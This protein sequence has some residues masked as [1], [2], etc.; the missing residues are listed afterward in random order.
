MP[1]DLDIAV[2]SAAEARAFSLARDLADEFESAGCRSSLVIDR[3]PPVAAGHTSCLV[4]PHVEFDRWASAHVELVS[5]RLRHTVAICPGALGLDAALALRPARGV[6][7]PLP[8]TR[9]MLR[10]AGIDAL[11]LPVGWRGDVCDAGE[12][13]L[14]VVV[15]DNWTAARWRVLAGCARVLDG[16][17]CDL[18]ASYV[19]ASRAGVQHLP[20][21]EGRRAL[22]RRAR[23][24]M[25]VG[26]GPSLDL[27]AAIEA[28]A[29]GA[30][31][32]TDARLDMAPFSS[33]LNVVRADERA[34]PTVLDALLRDAPRLERIRGDAAEL[35][36]RLS[37]SHAVDAIVSMADSGSTSPR[38]R[39]P[40][41]PAAA[42]SASAEASPEIPAVATILTELR[43]LGRRVEGLEHRAAAGGALAPAFTT[44]PAWESVA[45][46]LSVVVPLHDYEDFVDTACASVAA[47]VGVQLELI[48]VDDAS[49]DHGAERVEAF[50]ADHPSLPAALARLPANVGIA[51]A[52][53]HG[54]GLARA[55]LVLFLDAD[56]VLLPHGSRLLLD[57]LELD[58]G[59]AFAYG[60][61]AIEG[62]EGPRGLLNAEPWN[63]DLLREGNYI[64]ALALVR[65]AAFDQIGGFRADGLLEL[66]WEDYDFWLRMAGAGLR[67]T[68]V[69]Q[70][71]ARY[72]AHEGSRTVT[73]DTV[74]AELMSYL[75][76]QHPEILGPAS[77]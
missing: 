46:E 27:L 60:L 25:V 15:C 20:D 12:R 51:G 8:A 42:A 71:V 58:P 13:D 54:R 18:R 44:T 19:G 70:L 47:A 59:A 48:V 40:R 26:N 57:A 34:L 4:V 36:R 50:L 63:P 11:P 72:R 39:L 62:P 14:D 41:A 24:A 43:R 28:A 67:G 68:Q 22:L 56:D 23:V 33:G 75:R 17:A 5:G 9:H 10:I 45:P 65:T 1:A 3:L 73:A 61:L 31:I 49:N 32:V 37:L 74:A 53:N 7:A 77:V 30:V 76:Q 55:P 29:C 2:A 35:A 6:L 16:R 66:G 21:T 69:R 38:R 64:N 52:R